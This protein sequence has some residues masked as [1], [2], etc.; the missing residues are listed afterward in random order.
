MRG[1]K[2]TGHVLVVVSVTARPVQASRPVAVSVSVT[3][4]QLFGTLKLPVKFADAPG[5]KLPRVNTTVFAAGWLS[6]TTMFESVML[7]ALLT[8]P[9]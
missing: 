9:L 7:P 5:A 1:V 8:V 2:R 3:L 4:Q 6:T